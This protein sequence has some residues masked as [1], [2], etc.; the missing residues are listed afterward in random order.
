MILEIGDGPCPSP[1]DAAPAAALAL[2]LAGDVVLGSSS[3]KE[4]RM[5][6]SLR[7]LGLSVLSGTKP[8]R[9]LISSSSTMRDRR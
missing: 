4:L 5:L 2:F 6:E 9:M 8:S 3:K 7:P 1:R